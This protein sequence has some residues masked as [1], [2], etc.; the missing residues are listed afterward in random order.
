M[1]RLFCCGFEKTAVD[2]II[3]NNYNNQNGEIKSMIVITIVTSRVQQII[4][5][6]MMWTMMSM[7]EAARDLI[8]VLFAFTFGIACY[9]DSLRLIFVYW[10]WVS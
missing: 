1:V 5:L 2:L 8:I 7:I 10:C 9:R 6:A 3:D 4:V